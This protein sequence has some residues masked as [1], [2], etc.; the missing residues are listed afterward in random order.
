M[1][2]IHPYGLL[3]VV[4]GVPAA[5]V[6]FSPGTLPGVHVPPFSPASLVISP[7]D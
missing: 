7:A 3:V 6:G 5:G 1:K 2:E 4:G